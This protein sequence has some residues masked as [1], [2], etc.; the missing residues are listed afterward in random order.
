MSEEI[1]INEN[2]EVSIWS[3]ILQADLVV[4]IVMLLLLFLSVVSWSIIFE[5]LSKL[6]KLNKQANKFEK[7]FWSGLNIETIQDNIGTSPSHPMEAVFITGMKELNISNSIKLKNTASNEVLEK[8]IE[9]VM[10]ST[11]NKELDNL[12]KSVNFLATTGSAAPFIGLFGTVWVIMNSFQSIA[13]AK[14][15]SIAIVAPGIAEALL[16]TAMGLL[17]AIPAVIAY[18]KI[19]SDINRYSTRLEVFLSDF[20][21]ILSRQISKK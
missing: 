3:L 12:E 6:R 4:R 2:L 10:V 20:N 9:K 7:T 8:R 18:N 21:T 1:N 14:N 13:T 11:F 16:A 17:A 19:S 5:K 15:T